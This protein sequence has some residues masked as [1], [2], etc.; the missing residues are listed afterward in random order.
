MQRETATY[1]GV[2]F[3]RYPQS[4]RDS[5]RRYFKG[6]AEIDGKMQKISLHRYIWIV[7][8]GPIPKGYHVHHIDGDVDNNTISNLALLLAHEHESF[9][10]QNA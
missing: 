9:H 8:R 7:E 3:H 10:C 1:N 4:E 6:W 2:K 5:D